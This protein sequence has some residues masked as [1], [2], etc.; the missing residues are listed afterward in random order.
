[1]PCTYIHCLV[2]TNTNNKNSKIIKQQV[3]S[4]C[5][6][7][8]PGRKNI[9]IASLVLQRF[10]QFDQF[11]LFLFAVRHPF[12]IRA[13]LQCLQGRGEGWKGRREG[14]EDKGRGEGCGW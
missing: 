12:V 9:K 13:I 14:R 11:L 8:V 2:V 3:E 6:A 5:Y 7:M 1:M 10:H 4:L